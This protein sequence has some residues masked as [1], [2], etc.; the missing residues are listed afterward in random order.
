M[1][2]LVAESCT[3]GYMGRC[4]AAHLLMFL[5]V[6]MHTLPESC[7]TRLS[8]DLR[9]PCSVCAGALMELSRGQTSVRLKAFQGS[10]T[11]ASQRLHEVS[12]RIHCWHVLNNTIP[13]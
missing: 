6:R 12:W 1:E 7:Y 13:P 9:H 8:T 11:K 10:S 2:R 5:V 3:R 4:S